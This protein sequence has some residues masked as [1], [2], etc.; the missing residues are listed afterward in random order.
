VSK[1]SPLSGLAE[2]LK[3][4]PDF[5][6]APELREAKK[7]EKTDSEKAHEI[8]EAYWVKFREEKRLREQDEKDK[9]NRTGKYDPINTPLG[10]CRVCVDGDV[11]Q[12]LKWESHGEMRFGG[13]SNSFRV[14][15]CYFCKTCGIVYAFPP[16][17]KA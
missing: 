12:R 17:A 6:L 11:V 5:F 7:L 14:H 9:K 16:K 3:D 1:K 10:K 8:R 15:D 2:L 13:P 4:D